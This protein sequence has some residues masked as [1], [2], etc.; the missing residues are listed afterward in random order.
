MKNGMT[1]AFVCALS[2]C[3]EYD[4]K[5]LCVE[6]NDGFD[7]EEVSVLQDAAGYP[8][9]Q[10]AIILNHDASGL[11]PDSSWR[12]VSVDIMPMFSDWALDF[13]GDDALITVKVWDG[14]DPTA[15]TPW[16][17]TKRIVKS[18]LSW[19]D[20]TLPSDSATA[21]ST[22]SFDQ[23][24][25]WAN[26]DFS[27]VIPDTGMN[28]EDYLVGITWNTLGIPAVGYSNFNLACDKNWTDWGS[29]WQLNSTTAS[30][31][32]CSWPMLQVGIETSRYQENCE[33]TVKTVE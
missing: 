20:V 31:E 19:A 10:D 15:S 7:I 30:A 17:V 14:S 25:A 26:F 12:V 4:L 6:V 32:E 22:G 18:D 24:W 9:A 11:G 27:D 29:G 23:K 1:F 16:E 3:S 33:E 28:S 5:R 2:A 8:G 13:Y 21:G